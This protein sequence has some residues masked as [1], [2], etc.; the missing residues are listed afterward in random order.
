VKRYLLYRSWYAN[1]SA[2]VLRA[3]GAAL[4]NP[5][6]VQVAGPEYN[7]GDYA[8]VIDVDKR[9]SIAVWGRAGARSHRHRELCADH[10][11]VRISAST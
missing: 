8:T 3:P 2:S 7:A 10:A 6:H 4:L 1:I 9:V 5:W 11:G